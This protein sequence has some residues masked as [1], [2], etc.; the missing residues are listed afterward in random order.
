MNERVTLLCFR[1]WLRAAK[2]LSSPEEAKSFFLDTFEDS[3]IGKGA[4]RG[5]SKYSLLPQ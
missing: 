3:Y 2:S 1:N 5:S 4:L